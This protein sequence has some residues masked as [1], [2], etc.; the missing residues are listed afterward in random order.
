MRARVQQRLAL[1]PAGVHEH[2]SRTLGWVGEQR[3]QL[4]RHL[5]GAVLQVLHDDHGELAEQRRA[6]VAGDHP[7]VEAARRQLTYLGVRVGLAGPADDVGDRAVA[8]QL[9]GPGHQGDR[10]N[11]RAGLTVCR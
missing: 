11:G 8:Q 4:R 9:L 5:V 2:Q 6:R 1:D 7:G 3:L 10:R